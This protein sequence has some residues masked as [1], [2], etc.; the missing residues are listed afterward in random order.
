[1]ADVY[2]GREDEFEDRGRKVIAQGDLEIGVFFVDG[3]FYA[4]ENKCVHQGGPICQGRILNRVVELIADDKTSQGLAW[5][6]EDV[7]IVCPWH[8]YEFNIKTGI[9]PGS[10]NARLRS[11]DVKVTNGEVHVVV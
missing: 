9:H 8:G 7:H 10:K 3:E 6:E 4:W 5:S 2:V 1:M 11:F